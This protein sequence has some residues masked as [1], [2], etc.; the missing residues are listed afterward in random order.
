[1]IFT[2]DGYTRGSVRIAHDFGGILGPRT[3]LSHAT[4]LDEEE[5][6]I[7]AETGTCIVHNP[8]AIA[9]ILGALPGD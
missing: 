8:S 4:D 7:C 1:M 3:V 5:I 6:A 2:Q 9:S